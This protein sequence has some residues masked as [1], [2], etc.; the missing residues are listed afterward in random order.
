VLANVS[1][2]HRVSA[3]MLRNYFYHFT[4]LQVAFFR[5]RLR[6][7]DF[8][9]F[10]A[11]KD[12]EFPYP[13]FPLSFPDMGKH[14]CENFF[15]ITIDSKI[16]PDILVYLRAVYLNVYHPG[17]RCIFLQV[18]RH[19]VIKPHSGSNN[20][21][22]RV[23]QHI[24]CIVAVHAKHAGEKPVIM[25]ECRYPEQ[26]DSH[27]YASLFGKGFQLRHCSGDDYPVAGQNQGPL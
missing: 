7:D 18:S 24:G 9:V 27:G 17:L 3:G 2:H 4:H 26:G 16:C 1:H 19:A 6:P 22:S 20:Q 23:C 15:H 21:V 25:A 11:V 10:R 8:F 12:P 5:F 13:F 14:C